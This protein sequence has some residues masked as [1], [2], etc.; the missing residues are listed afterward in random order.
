[1]RALWSMLAAMSANAKK[2]FLKWTWS[3]GAQK[4]LKWWKASLA[5]PNITMRLCTEINPD[6][7][8]HVYTDASTSWGIGIIIGSEFDRFKLVE[9]WRDGDDGKRDIGWAE[10]I[11]VE[12]AVYFLLS[13][14]RLH[15][16]HFTI[17]TDN[18]GVIGAWKSRSSRNP[19]QN[20]VLGRIIRMLLKSQCY[21]SL[22]YVPS[23]E[24]PADPPSRGL[25]T[26]S[27]RRATWPGFPTKLRG[28]LHRE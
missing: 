7:S 10:F 5:V 20:E 11:A 14:H 22:S 18:Q 9:D 27:L 19:A 2:K 8:Y 1:M 16:R 12:M 24:N 28:L 17:H 15:N 21:L 4:D 25:T 13:I 23:E 3:S 26:P 6:D